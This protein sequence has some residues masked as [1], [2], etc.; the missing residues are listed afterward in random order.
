MSPRSHL[1]LRIGALAL[2]ACAAIWP[3]A[4]GG[5]T[6]DEL[7]R[8]G[9]PTATARATAARAQTTAARLVSA[10]GRAK[11]VVA[12]ADESDLTN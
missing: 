3:R 9:R 1:S 2:L 11:L 12:A 6:A 4:R 5:M 10:P 7:S 8:A